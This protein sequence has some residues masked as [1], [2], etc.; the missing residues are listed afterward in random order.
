MHNGLMFFFSLIIANN[1]IKGYD[2]LEALMKAHVLEGKDT[3]ELKWK[4]EALE[5]SVLQMASTKGVDASRALTYAI[6]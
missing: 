1:A 6:L 4:K 3:W 2:T 5:L